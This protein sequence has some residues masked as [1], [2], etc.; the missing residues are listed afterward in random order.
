MD[1]AWKNKLYFGDCL[2]ILQNLYNNNKEGFIDLVYV[3]PPFNSK[4]NYNILFEEANLTDTKAQKEAF[5]DTWSNVTYKDTLNSIR[6]LD[7]DLFSFLEALDRI[8]ISKSAIAYLTMMAIR[9]HYIHKV[10]KSTGSFYLHCDP[11][12]SHYLKLVCDLIFSEKNFRNEIIWKRTNAKGLASTKLPQ[13]HDIILYYS[14]TGNNTWNPLYLHHDQSYLTNFYR[15]TEKKTGRIYRLAD[16]TNPNKDRPNL[17]YE[18]LG[19][20]RVWRWTKERMENAYKNGLIVQNKPSSVPQMKRYLD[21][22]KG[23]ALDDT[24]VDI[25]MNKVSKNERLGYPTQKPLE[26]MERIISLSSNEGDLVADFFCGC[27]TTIAAAQQ[28]NRHWIGVDISHLAI[29]LIERRLI[30]SYGDQIKKTYDIHGFP[31]DIDSARKL[32]TETDK[33]RYEFQKWIIEAELGGICNPKKT[34]D[35]GWDGHLTFDMQG[36][37]KVILIEVKSGNVNV[38]NLREFIHVVKK[39]NADIGVFICF[40]E[41]VT[42]PMKLAAK[43]EGYFSEEL[44]GDRYDKIQLVT[45]DDILNDKG[46]DFPDSRKMTFKKAERK[47]PEEKSNQAKLEL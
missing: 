2:E 15:Y 5:A 11:T 40:N 28:K 34:A 38:K 20:T 47:A 4:R 7:L 25:S 3:D 22:Q 33:P 16:L 46:I 37:K 24:W 13:D 35:G 26:L 9:I 42:K 12:M 10:L 1:E 36:Q 31:K 41:Q 32:A 39:Q 14:K 17:T 21:E 6:E 44:Y 27:G 19:I 23:N 45:V 30:D 43:E 29:G 8:R 18:F